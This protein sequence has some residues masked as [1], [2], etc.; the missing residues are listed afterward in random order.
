MKQGFNP[1]IL[2]TALELPFTIPLVKDLKI[3]GRLDRVDNLGNGE[4]EIV[5]YKT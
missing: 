4:I 3:G 1:N 2:P 5:D